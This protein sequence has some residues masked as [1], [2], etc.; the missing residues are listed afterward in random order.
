MVV[1]TLWCPSSSCT[2]RMRAAVGWRSPVTAQMRVA[3]T[4]THAHPECG[5]GVTW[6]LELQ[7]GRTR[8]TL[9]SGISHGATPVAVGPVP[10]QNGWFETT[11]K[12]EIH[13]NPPDEFF[14]LSGNIN[15][16]QLIIDTWCIPEPSAGLLTVLGGGLLLVLRWRRQS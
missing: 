3:G 12:W 8:Q 4:V 16:D 7:R 9:A 10:L 5:N 15:V 1:S 6:T 13:P 14:V 2:V 11:Y